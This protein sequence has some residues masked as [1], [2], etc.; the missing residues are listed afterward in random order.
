MYLPTLFIKVL[1][2]V[3]LLSIE[4]IGD[5]GDSL[6]L[7]RCTF[8]DKVY[9]CSLLQKYNS[10]FFEPLYVT[11]FYTVGRL[12][13]PTRY[14][15][16]NLSAQSDSTI[17]TVTRGAIIATK[18]TKTN[19]LNWLEAS[20]A[21]A[22]SNCTG[23]ILIRSQTYNRFTRC[24]S[25]NFVALPIL[26]EQ[27]LLLLHFRKN[28][29]HIDVYEFANDLYIV[30]ARKLLF[31]NV[32]LPCESALMRQIRSTTM[33]DD[34]F[35]ISL[36]C[37]ITSRPIYVVFDKEGKYNVFYPHLNMTL[38]DTFIELRPLFLQFQSDSMMHSFVQS[39]DNNA[40][41]TTFTILTLDHT[42]WQ[43]QEE[44]QQQVLIGHLQKPKVGGGVVVAY[45]ALRLF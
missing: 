2:G 30:T 41:T 6:Q 17:V 13:N 18:Q 25:T 28:T 38:F 10:S 26:C 32:M 34:V 5:G 16:A 24:F 44:T 33:S 9:T 45:D 11:D 31:T 8:V 27:S 14:V 40:T 1:S 21:E 22:N 42:L 20:Y 12:V 3:S 43:W 35:T 19:A 23:F 39:I 36:R 37:S 15:L 4:H 7:K 29:L